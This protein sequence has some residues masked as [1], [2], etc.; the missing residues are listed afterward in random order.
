MT[1]HYYLHKIHVLLA[2][3][4]NDEELRRLCYDVPDF[5]PVYDQL[6]RG[7]G[8]ADIVDRLVEYAEQKVLLET[9][10]E[11]A[12]KHNPARYVKHQPYYELSIRYPS[13]GLAEDTT[14]PV[15]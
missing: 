14:P 10:L 5:R 7:T 15:P 12:K 3:G 6:A 11:L 4:F 8:K 13:N 9:L 2:Y 1:K